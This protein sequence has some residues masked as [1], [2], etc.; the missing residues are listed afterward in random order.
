MSPMSGTAAFQNIVTYAIAPGKQAAVTLPRRRL[1]DR[2]G[3]AHRQAD[4]RNR[5][6]SETGR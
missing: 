4:H 5:P 2:H 1:G 6:A 3:H